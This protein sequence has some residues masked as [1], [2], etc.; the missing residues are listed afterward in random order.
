MKNNILTASD[1]DIYLCNS[2]PTVTDD[3]TESKDRRQKDDGDCDKKRRF[4]DIIELFQG[5]QNFAFYD[6]V[7]AYDKDPMVFWRWLVHGIK[8][9]HYSYE[10]GF[11]MIFAHKN[12][13]NGNG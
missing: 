10:L 5:E 9:G 1:E 7:D 4:E 12:W 6:A 11:R 2:K 3:Q 8:D 13:S